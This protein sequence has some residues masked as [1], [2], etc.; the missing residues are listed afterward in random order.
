MKEVK[1]KPLIILLIILMGIGFRLLTLDISYSYISSYEDMSVNP[2]GEYFTIG[3]GELVEL[4][5]EI[6]SID[7]VKEAY[8]KYLRKAKFIGVFLFNDNVEITYSETYDAY[9]FSYNGGLLV[10]GFLQQYL[11][12]LMKCMFFDTSSKKRIFSISSMNND[13]SCIASRGLISTRL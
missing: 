12:G 1:K 9:Y 4:D 2:L 3:F 7:E 8:T 5:E 11:A 13:I 6:T 10:E